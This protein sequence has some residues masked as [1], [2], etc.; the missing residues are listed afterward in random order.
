MDKATFKVLEDLRRRESFE[1]TDSHVHPLD[2]M[3]IVAPNEESY[4]PNAGISGVSML[5][6]LDYNSFANLTIRIIR[7]LKPSVIA[8]YISKNYKSSSPQRLINVMR[9]AGVDRAVLVPLAPWV[10]TSQLSEAF[11]GNNKFNLLGTVDIHGQDVETIREDIYEQI[12]THNIVGIKMHPNLQGFYPQPSD[13][14]F[15]LREKL[16]SIYALAAEHNL[17]LLFHGGYTNLLKKSVRSRRNSVKFQLSRSAFLRNFINEDGKSE[18]LGQY[19]IPIIIAHAG[20]YALIRKEYSLIEKIT[21]NYK[22]VYF[23]TSGVSSQLVRWFIENR[24]TDRL[25]FGSDAF[26]HNMKNS[27]KICVSTILKY[28]AT[29]KRYENVAAVLGRN[30]QRVKKV[31]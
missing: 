6:Q 21:R 20:N 16:E 11:S 31:L 15:E 1:V 13:N 5:E 7:I 25:I 24:L 14:T 23:D 17:Y 28:S 3:G 30:Y 2:V 8:N 10:T 4:S 27:L 29:D 19:D 22:K 12:K 26:Y 9:E 18:L